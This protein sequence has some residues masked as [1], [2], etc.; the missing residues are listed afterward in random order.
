[1]SSA[2][3]ALDGDSPGAAAAMTRLM[4][5]QLTLRASSPAAHGWRPSQT[6]E[7][8]L[9]QGWVAE[10]VMSVLCQ[11]TQCS[12]NR[13]IHAPSS[14]PSSTD[15]VPRPLWSSLTAIAQPTSLSG[16]LPEQARQASGTEARGSNFLRRTLPDL[17]DILA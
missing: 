6:M 5:D 10:D 12:Q 16:A 11:C 15:H 1:M 14:N 17:T 7:G 2:V 4:S 8:A 13:S 9:S 3:A